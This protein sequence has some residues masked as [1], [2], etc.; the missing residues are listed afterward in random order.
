MISSIRIE[1]FRRFDRFDM[2]DLG[3]VNLLVGANNSGKTSI[4][5]ALHLLT[6]RSDPFALWRIH[7]RRGERAIAHARPSEPEVDVSHLFTGHELH[8]GSEFRLS[9]MNQSPHRS[10][11]VKVEELTAKERDFVRLPGGSVPRLCLRLTG[12]PRPLVAFIPLSTSG[13]LSSDSLEMPRRGRRRPS[14]ADT[15]RVQYITTEAMDGDDL[16]EMWDAIALTPD[17]E[18]VLG[19]LACLDPGIERIAA[20]AGTEYWGGISNRSGFIVK[21]KRFENPVPMGS[22]GDGLW[23]LLSLAIA[24][25]QCRGGVLLVDEIDTGL[26]HTAMSDM[27]KL[28]ISAAERFD[29]QVFATTHSSDCVNSIAL[30]S[31]DLEYSQQVTLQRIEPDRQRATPYS[32]EEVET[33]SRH[34]V[35]VR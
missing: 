18:L 4:L 30:S 12:P 3:R 27:W 6:S 1:G 9:A 15:S 19:A 11:S 22:M 26:H 14:P 7:W 35:E 34:A 2:G 20:Q 8:L 21:H 17:E 33:A 10:L 24:I 5:E 16:V 31:A 13:T 32:A 25:T 28:I 23:R 29:V